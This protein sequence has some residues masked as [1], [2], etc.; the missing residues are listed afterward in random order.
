[1]GGGRKYKRSTLFLGTYNSEDCSRKGRKKREKR[2][3]GY[4]AKLSVVAV[5]AIRGKKEKKKDAG[6][7]SSRISDRGEGRR[8]R[9]T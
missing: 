1:M 5:F 3:T 4:R 8:A 6:D 9:S 7:P 2:G